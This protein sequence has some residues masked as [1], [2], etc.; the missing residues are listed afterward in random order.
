MSDEVKVLLVA[1][2][3]S[4]GA[5][6]AVRHAGNMAGRLG[7]PVELLFAFPAS[8]TDMFGVPS[9][10]FSR[11]QLRYFSPEAFEELRERTAAQVLGTA[12]GQLADAGVEVREKVLAGSPAE[13]I[14]D[15]AHQVPGA[16][17]VMGR[18]GLSRLREMVVGSVSQSVLHGA[19]CPVTL[20][21]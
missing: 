12:R 14:M 15:Y 4:K 2:D 3:G 6:A 11:E 16:M 10:A 18:R 19:S 20:V 5:E 13:A 9:E 1:V 21:R 7:L 17:I 8:P